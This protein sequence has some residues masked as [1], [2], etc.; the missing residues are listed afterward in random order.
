MYIVPVYFVD[1][2]VFLVTELSYPSFAFAKKVF[3]IFLGQ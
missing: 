3:L 2:V 1:F